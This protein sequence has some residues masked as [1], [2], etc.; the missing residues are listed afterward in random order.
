MSQVVVLGSLNMDLVVRVE[1]HPR[2]GETVSGSEF[3]T[4]PGGKG[5]NQA[6]AAAR[7][8]AQVAMAGRV[9]SDA[10]GEAALSNLQSRGV[11]TSRVISDQ[12]AP[13][14]IAMIQVDKAGENSIVVAPGANGRVS[15]QDVDELRG[16][17][18]RAS[19][20]LLQFEIPLNSVRRAIEMA[21]E[22][23]VRVIL[24]PAPASS[25]ADGFFEG[26]NIL[27]VNETEAELLGGRAV[28]GVREASAAASA[29]R[30]LGPEVVIVTLGAGGAYFQAADQ[31]GHV[32]A[33][34]VKVV[35]TTAAGDTFAGG[36]VAALLRG[37][38]LQEAV[39]Y[40]TC[41][42]SLATMRLGAQT[43]IPSAAEVD[44]LYNS[45][46]LPVL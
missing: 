15:C 5:A 29:L 18:S 30:A 44:A 8:G 27:V 4:I 31:E 43:S 41:A 34:S 46:E 45:G 14:G 6:A 33:P 32:P 1:R 9:G 20:L 11:A 26:V 24:N 35:D 19:F 36:L 42:G 10:F 40:A 16:L 22:L 12:K 37:L 2:P 23:G 17:I 21:N 13:S 38:R 25:V 3:V 39:R 7:L 28:S